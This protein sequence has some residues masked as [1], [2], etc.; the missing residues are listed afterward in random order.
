MS[1]SLEFVLIYIEFEN[2]FLREILNIA[3]KESCIS[4][5]FSIECNENV[6]V[7]FSEIKIYYTSDSFCL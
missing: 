2:S 7:F 6:L 3:R 5:G 4:F 1:L